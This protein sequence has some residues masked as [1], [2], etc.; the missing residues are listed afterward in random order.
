M[1]RRLPGARIATIAFALSLIA[2]TTSCSMVSDVIDKAKDQIPLPQ[3]TSQA[4]SRPTGVISTGPALVVS[5]QVVEPAGGSIKVQKAGDPLDG[6]EIQIPPGAYPDTRQVNISYA[7]VTNHTF[8]EYFTPATP[9]ISI[10]NG[11]DY[12]DEFMTVRIPV[13]I[14]S[15]GFAMAFYYDEAK[16]TLEAIPFSSIEADSITIVTRH[17]CSIIASIINQTLMDDLLKTDIDSHFRPGIDDWQ[18]TNRGSFIEPGGH[19]AGQSLSAMW[20]FCEQP[21]GKDRT[22]YG[23]YDNNG[24]QPATPALWEDDSYGY[25]LASAVQHDINWG[26]FE[27]KL[28]YALAQMSDEPIFKA[29]AYSIQLT[30]EPQEVGLF[31]SGGGGH[32]MICYRVYNNNLYVADP[33]YPGDTERRIEYVDGEFKSYKSGANA[34][35]I[36]AGHGEAYEIIQFCAKSATVDWG[37]IAARWAELKAGAV[38]NDVFPAYQIV[39]ADKDGNETPLVDGMVS[40]DKKIAIRVKGNISLAFKIYRD[41]A[42]L[43]WDADHKYELVDGDNLLGINIYGDVNGNPQSRQWEY[44]DFQYLHVQYGEKE[45]HGWVLE[46]VTP[47]IEPYDPG[48]ERFYRDFTITASEGDYSAS[49]EYVFSPGDSTQM[50]AAYAESGSWSLL[51]DC[52]QPNETTSLSV[53]LDTSLSISPP[54]E[55]GVVQNI[56][57]IT[58]DDSNQTVVHVVQEADS[59]SPVLSQTETA[60]FMLGDNE[61]NIPGLFHTIQVRVSTDAGTA[62]YDYK[63]VWIG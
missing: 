43:P 21:D 61:G 60:Q 31:S 1:Y 23:R 29:F 14:P 32:D 48:D 53:T 24:A 4:P 17:F 50:I 8:G 28:M 36:A 13:D 33:N 5:S 55:W 11:G 59:A 37:K 58:V 3:A 20:Y 19:C 22:L 10:E 52:I 38:G 62:R 12:S 9:L 6:L 44:V 40:K 39:V 25:R 57:W 51:P 27:N 16:G 35:E 45:C 47:T 42:A 46:S 2:T 56:I 15:G 30:G 49:G 34:D 18:F 7:P 26:S 63:Y 54:Q 41:G